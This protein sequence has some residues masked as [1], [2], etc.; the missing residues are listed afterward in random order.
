MLRALLTREETG[1]HGTFG[2]LRVDDHVWFTGEL[3]WRD[4]AAD[5]SSIPPG[6]YPCL[7]TW[8]NRFK[9]K[10]YLVDKVPARAGVR[11]HPANVMG[12]KA[13]GFRCQLNGCVALG[14]KRG[15][16]AGQKAIL[17]SMPA[18]TSLEQYL[19]G[20]PFELEIIQ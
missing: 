10:M 3:P 16:M 13:L 5:I 18:V 2:R 9:R 15:F 8:S 14:E 7:W 12:D 1:D 6:V 4:N 11:I 19:Q 20:Q 17:V